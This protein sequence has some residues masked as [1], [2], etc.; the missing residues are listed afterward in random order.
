MRRIVVIAVVVIVS[1]C[2]KKG[3]TFVVSLPPAYVVGSVEYQ[4][5][6]GDV[7]RVIGT[8]N[9]FVIC[10]TCPKPSDLERLLAP[11]PVVIK[12]SAPP[13]TAVVS[14][15]VTVSTGTQ[16]DLQQPVERSGAAG[17]VTDK[18]QKVKVENGVVQSAVTPASPADPNQEKAA[19]DSVKEAGCQTTTVYFSLNSAAV[20]RDEQQK[21]IGS[22]DAFKGKNVE[23]LGYTCDLG[24]KSHNDELAL[25][26]AKAVAKVLEENDVKPLT[27]SGE[28]KCCYVSEDRHL[29]RRAEISCV[30]K[31]LR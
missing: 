1:G 23:I 22:L 31:V 12:F 19:R 27:V 4:H 15:P 8:D 18:T 13:T 29:N 16:G 9:E 20:G 7:V 21:I 6:Y 11:V 2:M 28:G 24:S 17:S 25:A 14:T 3:D 10:E 26:R 5:S 30:G